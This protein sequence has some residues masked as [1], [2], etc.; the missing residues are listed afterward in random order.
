MAT[1]GG[2][3]AGEAASLAAPVSIGPGEHGGYVCTAP[4]YRAEL[5]AGGNLRSLRVGPT[6]CLAGPA[7]FVH[8]GQ[9]V[10]LKTVRQTGPDAAVAEGESMEGLRGTRTDFG[11]I[12][13]HRNH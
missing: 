2:Q 8:A 7:A 3:K 6:E 9:F 12:R 10:K 13:K 11:T 1:L 5:D 4:A